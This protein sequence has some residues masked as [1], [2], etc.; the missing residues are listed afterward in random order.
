VTAP[1][2]IAAVLPHPRYRIAASRLVNAPADRVWDALLA[3]P[4][5]ALP[6]GFALTVLRHLPAVLAN[7]EQRV[8]A[9]DTF[10][11]A[12]PIP[13]VFAER[14]RVVISAGPSQAWKWRGGATPPVVDAQHF[15]D[16]ADAGW[17]KV[18]MEFRLDAVDGGTR[19]STET[20]VTPTDPTTARRFAPYWWA[21]RLGSTLIRREVIAAVARRAETA[22]EPR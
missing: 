19:L 10:L 7:T 4:M 22:V 12:T 21:I 14:P 13:V 18:A 2:N 16:W 9:S 6:V 17:I 5:G 8:R 15:A 3:L 1:L 20:R 11:A